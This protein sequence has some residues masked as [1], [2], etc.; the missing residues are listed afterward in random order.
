MPDGKKSSKS[1]KK[2]D[3]GLENTGEPRVEDRNDLGDLNP[4]S[5]DLLRI[6]GHFDVVLSVP[7]RPAGDPGK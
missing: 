3:K 5:G 6:R 2:D 7:R 4:D 1:A